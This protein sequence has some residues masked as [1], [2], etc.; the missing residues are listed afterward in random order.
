MRYYLLTLG[1]IIGVLMLEAHI[2]LAG[3]GTD[4]PTYLHSRDMNCSQCMQAR[5]GCAWALSVI[6]DGASFNRC[7]TG[8][9]ITE[10]MCDCCKPL[11]LR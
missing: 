1:V 4:L 6:D 9:N 11:E 8:H 2:C 7:M 5:D 3:S 10:E